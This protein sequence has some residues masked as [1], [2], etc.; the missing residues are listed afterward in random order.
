MNYSAA[1]LPPRSQ[2]SPNDL[3]PWLDGGRFDGRRFD[4][5]RLGVE[6]LL[7]G[8]GGASFSGGWNLNCVGAK[9]CWLVGDGSAAGS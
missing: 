2:G 3:W 8:A 7:A 5:G 6:D 9:L 4:G 1:A